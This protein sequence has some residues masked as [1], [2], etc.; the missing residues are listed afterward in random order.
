MQ[1]SISVAT[2]VTLI[3]NNEIMKVMTTALITVVIELILL[4]MIILNSNSDNDNNRNRLNY[5]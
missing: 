1:I 2:M 5:I 3:M 4:I